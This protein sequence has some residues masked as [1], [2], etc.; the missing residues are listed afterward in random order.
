[1]CK[2]LSIV[3]RISFVLLTLLFN[4]FAVIASDE[5]YVVATSVNLREQPNTNAKIVAKL[6][7]ATK[8]EVYKADMQWVQVTVQHGSEKGK[9]GW[10]IAEYLEATRP[11]IWSLLTEFDLTPINDFDNRCKWATRAI[12]FDPSSVEA[13]NR[14]KQADCNFLASAIRSNDLPRVKELV[15][16]GANVNADIT[17]DPG[18]EENRGIT[19][20]IGALFKGH[21]EIASY[22]IKN[23]ANVN[24]VAA[25]GMGEDIYTPL[26]IATVNSYREVIE[27]LLSK[28]AS[29]NYCVSSA[30]G[31]N[32]APLHIAIQRNQ[33]DIMSLLIAKGADVDA[34]GCQYGGDSGYTPLMTA[35]G[36]GNMDAVNLLM[37][38]GA[39]VNATDSRGQT[40][41]AY[42][43]N[44]G[45]HRT[46]PFE[47]VR[48]LQH[49]IVR[50]LINHGAD[51]DKKVGKDGKTFKD[52]AIERADRDL[53]DFA[54]CLRKERGHPCKAY[55][56]DVN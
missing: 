39:N 38:S 8:V 47:E 50:L 46:G 43:L 45:Y 22:L 20:L 17:G 24:S 51:L 6:P 16:A 49:Q 9:R 23:G 7:I 44:I 4:P 15:R 40:A 29:P 19:P 34:P 48:S 56:D 37:K 42:V 52:F 10:L 32:G 53:A 3:K 28:G 14:L 26:S 41:L 18:P 33:M 54:W 31:A 36:T 27:L 35:V 2:G 12:A 30:G 55:W 11:E 25:L 5:R 1:M 13:Q 21:L